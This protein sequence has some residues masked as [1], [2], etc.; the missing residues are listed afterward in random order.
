MLRAGRKTRG[1]FLCD[2][3]VDWIDAKLA[4]K[5]LAA[6]AAGGQAIRMNVTA[7][8]VTSSP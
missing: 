2:G 6:I 3:H 7:G 8:T 1:G 5:L 4:A